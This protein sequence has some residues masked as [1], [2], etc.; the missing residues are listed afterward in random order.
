MA[1]L[2]YPSKEVHLHLVADMASLLTAFH[3]C[4]C[5]QS[6][7]SLLDCISGICSHFCPCCSSMRYSCIA[8]PSCLTS[9]S[10]A[11]K[12]SFFTTAASSASASTSLSSGCTSSGVVD[13]PASSAAALP[14]ARLV[15]TECISS[16]ATALAFGWHGHHAYAS[17]P[18]TQLIILDCLVYC[19]GAEPKACASVSES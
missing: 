2:G 7:L 15:P 6:A 16:H 5:A 9:T 12:G 17:I 8:K 4:T 19:N 14:L 3:T 13:G 11:A 18:V 1:V 10:Y